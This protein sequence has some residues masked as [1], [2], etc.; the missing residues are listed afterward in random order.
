MRFSLACEDIT[1]DNPVFMNGFG[2]RSH[3]SEGI[4]DPLF[5]KAVLLEADK[6]LLLLTIDAV[7][8]DH[9]FTDGIKKSLETAYGLRHED[10]MINYS[11]THAS[12]FLTG[13]DKGKRRG[14]YSMGQ[15]MPATSEH[16]LDYSVDERYYDAVEAAIGRM[17][18]DCF[19]RLEEGQLS[20]ALAAS[21]F[22]ISRRKP[23]G[24][25]GVEWAPYYE[26]EIDRD[27]FV[28]KL[29]DRAGS[30]KGILYSYGCHTTAVGGDNYLFSGDYAG[31]ASGWLEQR[32]PGVTAMFLQGCGGEVKPRR[33]AIGGTFKSCSFTEMSEI[34]ADLGHE[35]ARLLEG[36]V[37]TPVD[38]RRF[39][40]VLLQPVLRTERI[41]L[42]RHRALADNEQAIPFM[43]RAALRSIQAVQEG[44]ARD[45]LPLDIAVWEL[46]DEMRIV[47]IEGE[48]STQ[49][50]LKIKK[51]FGGG[52]TLVLGYT[53]AVICYIPTRAMLREGGYEADSNDA[54]GMAG[55]F[56]P[57]IEEQIL[58]S[59]QSAFSGN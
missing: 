35:V 49:Y 58:T 9:S 10:I 15:E 23:D 30:P 53:N 6:A 20:I 22:G 34:G 42:E 32:Y 25:G 17:V 46:D 27:L 47:A 54:F 31:A 52:K 16:E 43:R 36:G 57:E 5:V 29:T 51:L 44:R 3:K 40:S 56:L 14:G 39:R 8:S 45:Q 4:H 48:V 38:C 41:P 50:G 26:G 33:S 13:R 7:G 59:V 11:H 28:L 2:T 24:N 12:L 1:P 19:K 18:G 37:W 55:P 21:D